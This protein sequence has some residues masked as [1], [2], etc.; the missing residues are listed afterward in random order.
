MAEHRALDAILAPGGIT[1]VFQPI[2][3]F[4]RQVAAG[5]RQGLFGFECFSRG[6]KGTN[7]ESARVLFEYIRLK[8]EEPLVDRAC[9]AAA[10]AHA[11]NDPLLQLTINVHASTLVRDRDFT[12]FLCGAAD[13]H[14][15]DCGRITIEI[16][17]HA[18]S[19]DGHTLV[20]ALGRLRESG[21]R[22]SLDDIGLGQSNFKMILDVRPDFLKLDRYFVASCHEDGDRR[23]VIES[24]AHLA[25]HFGAEII[26]EGVDCAAAADALRGLGVRLMQGDWFAAPMEDPSSAFGTFSPLRR[27]EG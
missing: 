8:H 27:G 2:V 7:F 13:A 21:M 16:V 3:D 6:P 14:E 19:W 12:N 22:V 23:A 26:A 17:E 4:S 1:P 18:P 11:P 20:H 25:T 10:L 9:V 15:I 5:S 24:V